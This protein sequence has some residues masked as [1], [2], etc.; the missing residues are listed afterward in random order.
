MEA[1]LTGA[2]RRPVAGA[3]GS[4][5]RTSSRKSAAARSDYEEAQIMA[6]LQALERLK[7][8]CQVLRLFPASLGLRWPV[9][10]LTHLPEY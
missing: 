8:M 10:H 9:L 2:G 4:L 6:R 7:D 1:G 5:P 3:G